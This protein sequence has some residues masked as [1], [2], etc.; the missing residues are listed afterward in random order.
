MVCLMAAACSGTTGAGASVS[1]GPPAPI[2]TTSGSAPSNAPA[3]DG[4][5]R[6]VDVDAA[7]YRPTIAG[8]KVL[9]VGETGQRSTHVAR[10]TP[11]QRLTVAGTPAGTAWRSRILSEASRAHPDVPFDEARTIPPLTQV[12][13]F[14][15]DMTGP[16]TYVGYVGLREIRIPFVIDCGSLRQ[17]GWIDTWDGET[18]GILACGQPADHVKLTL[19]ARRYCVDKPQ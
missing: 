6:H 10:P 3:C 4:G 15:D 5:S 8:A 13:Q 1:P 9:V 7:S 16:G 12:E 18:I 14:F 19:L 11:P 2:I 17:H